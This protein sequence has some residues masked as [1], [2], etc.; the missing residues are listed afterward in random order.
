MTPALPALCRDCL[1]RFSA[2][3]GPGRARCPACRSPRTLRHAELETLSIA[4]V[5]CDAFYASVE[6]RDDPAL[7]D[8]PVI[9]G[10]GRRGVVSAACYLARMRGVRSAMPMFQAMRLCPDAAVRAPRMEVYAHASRRIRALM[11]ELTPLVEPLSLDEAFLDLSGCERLHRAPPAALL[12]RLARRIEDEVG[13][14]V[15]VGLSHCKFLAKIAS[16]LDKPRGYSLIGRAETE[17]FLR[18]KPLSIIWGV[19]EA[20]RARLARDGLTHV[21]DVLRADPRQLIARHGAMGR[22]LLELAQGRDSRKVAPDAPTR[23]LSAETTFEADLSA[24]DLLD[25]HLWRLVEKVAARAKARGLAGRVA[26]LKLK[27]A[28]HRLLTRRATLTEPTQ[29]AD[30]LHRALRPLLE[31]ALPEAPFRLIGAG[32]SELTQAQEGDRMADLLDPDAARRAQAE[33]AADLI[34][35]RFG[36]GAIA[37]GRALSAGGFRISEKKSSTTRGGGAADQD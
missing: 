8:R 21:R 9:V 24:P 17:D 25:A 36:D 27:R 14:T 20:T 34:R 18:D 16:D 1:R 11:D 30:R 37:K 12:A 5:D 15:S 2:P 7:R 19:G 22:R 10:G 35:A 23:S 31:R 29:L 6:K 4:H 32:L 13:V 26:T 33:R 28:D 3:P